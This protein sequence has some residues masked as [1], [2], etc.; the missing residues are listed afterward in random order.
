MSKSGRKKKIFTIIISLVLVGVFVVI[1]PLL[2]FGG[3][4]FIEVVFN[5]PTEPKIKYGEFPF[6]IIYEYEGYSF[7]L[8][9][10]NTRD[11]K[12]YLK[13]SDDDGYYY[14]DKEN[15]PNL[16]IY[17]PMDAEYYMGAPDSDIEN[18][19]PYI[20]YNVYTESENAY[21]EDPS[22][23]IVLIENKDPREEVDIIIIE[24]KPSE[25]LANNFK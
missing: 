25:P 11:W 4:I 9:G 24:W 7:V 6:E 3:V 5:K 19:R 14:I 8:D 13:N 17:V 12:C 20:Y 22:E 10:G 1:A 18:A 15:Q 2:Y 21:E 23:E 16:Y